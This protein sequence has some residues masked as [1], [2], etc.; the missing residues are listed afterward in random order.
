MVLSQDLLQ[1]FVEFI[2]ERKTVSLEDLAAEFGL[3]VSDAIDRVR[4]LEAMGRLSGVMDD[5]GKVR[6]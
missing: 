3:R 1:A 6:T 4:S 5:R 2:V